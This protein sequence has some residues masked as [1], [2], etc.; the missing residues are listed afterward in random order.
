MRREADAAGLRLV[1][2]DI[3]HAVTSCRHEKTRRSGYEWSGSSGWSEKVNP[4]R[5][6]LRCRN[7]LLM[8]SDTRKIFRMNVSEVNHSTHGKVKVGIAVQAKP[9]LGCQGGMDAFTAA[10]NH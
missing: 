8:N 7:D 3:G 9:I 4:C 1:G 2:E 10:Q 6:D 5:K